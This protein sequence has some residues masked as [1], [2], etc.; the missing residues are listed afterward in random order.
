MD[1][2]PQDDD[3]TITPPCPQCCQVLV[4]IDSSTF[5]R[6]YHRM[7]VMENHKIDNQM[8]VFGDFQLILARI[9]LYR[10]RSDIGPRLKLSKP[11]HLFFAA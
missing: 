2:S 7:A 8:V 11:S 9:F 4:S 5:Y 3:V 1:V 10:V 6:F